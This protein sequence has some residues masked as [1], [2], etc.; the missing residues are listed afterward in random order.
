MVWRPQVSRRDREVLLLSA[1]GSLT[2]TPEG[3]GTGGPCDPCPSLERWQA[4]LA[5]VT[6]A[7]S[8]ATQHSP[9]PQLNSASTPWARGWPG[10]CTQPPPPGHKHTVGDPWALAP[11]RESIWVR[12]AQ[13]AG[14]WPGQRKNFSQQLSIQARDEGW[15]QG[16]A[17]WGRAKAGRGPAGW[18]PRV[19][20]LPGRSACQGEPD[21]SRFQNQRE[22]DGLQEPPPTMTR[23]CRC[24]PPQGP[25]RQP[26][27]LL[28]PPGKTHLGLWAA[29]PRA[30]AKPSPFL[31]SFPNRRNS[32][33]P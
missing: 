10:A 30:P 17:S 31:D 13:N 26:W 4:R 8:A 19:A 27:G 15:A 1:L 5:S 29:C 28:R 3:S 6:P 32:S 11:Q 24:P 7:V 16:H 25:S 22:L 9:P 12:T 23:N 21:R 2:P 20:C 33:R 14:L 18:P